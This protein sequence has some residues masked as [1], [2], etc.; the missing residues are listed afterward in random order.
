M[1]L[2][3]VVDGAEVGEVAIVHLGVVGNLGPLI[4]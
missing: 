2:A 4:A 1:R 3:A